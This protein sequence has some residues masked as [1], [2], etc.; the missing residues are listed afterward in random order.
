MSI[1]QLKYS[2]IGDLEMKEYTTNMS[3]SKPEKVQEPLSAYVSS[4][5]G[6]AQAVSIPHALMDQLLRQSNDVK[7]LIIQKLSES[8]MT[9]PQEDK[10]RAENHGA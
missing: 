6:N 9:P 2:Y 7:L 4:K 10:F 5:P 8:M 1:R 3:D